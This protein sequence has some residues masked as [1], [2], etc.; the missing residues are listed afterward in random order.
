M[1]WDTELEE[2]ELGE[3]VALELDAVSKFSMEKLDFLLPLEVDFAGSFLDAAMLLLEELEDEENEEAV[4]KFITRI[5]F[6][7]FST[8]LNVLY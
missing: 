2:L 6:N 5:I 4:S 7:G 3:L 1:S 8:F